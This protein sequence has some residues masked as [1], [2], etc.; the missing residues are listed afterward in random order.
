MAV[1]RA[2]AFEQRRGNRSSRLRVC[3][4]LSGH[5]GAY[6]RKPCAIW[7]VPRLYYSR[8]ME[9]SVGAFF[10]PLT[11]SRFHKHCTPSERPFC[12]HTAL[13]FLA[14]RPGLLR[15]IALSADKNSRHSA[16]PAYENNFYQF[17][18]EDTMK[19]LAKQYDPSQVEDRIY[20]FW[21]DGGCFHTKADPD[22]KPY[23]IV[24]PLR[25][26]PASSTWATPW[27][28]PCRT[29]SSAPSGCRAMPPC[30]CPARTTLP[31]LRRPRSW[32]PCVLRA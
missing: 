21:L 18:W 28:T 5:Q 25:T 27:I 12:P 15:K 10:V 17:I 1:R 31:S 29:S 9:R 13:I 22:K 8:P 16:H 7:V 23:T 14:I 3:P 19:E 6:G 20:Q 2:V 26:S 32:R 30:G 11:R 24:M 4:T